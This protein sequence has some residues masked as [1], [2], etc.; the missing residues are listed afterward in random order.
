MFPA[1][2]DYFRNRVD[3]LLIALALE[4]GVFVVSMLYAPFIPIAFVVV[5]ATYGC[6]F[7]LLPGVL[8]DYYGRDELSFVHGLVLQAWAS[9][10]ALAFF[11]TFLI[12]NVLKLDQKA[13]FAALVVVY[14]VNFINVLVLRLRRKQT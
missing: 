12:V 4:I 5:N 13:L 9:A 3:V 10:S 14:A 7:A 11:L 8:L 6:F 1:A 2:S